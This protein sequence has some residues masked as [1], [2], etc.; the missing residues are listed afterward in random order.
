MIS[1][2][3]SARSTSPSCTRCPRPADPYPAGAWA[4]ASRAARAF[5]TR[6]TA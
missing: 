6:T 4:A 3:P 2:T 5:S 1:G